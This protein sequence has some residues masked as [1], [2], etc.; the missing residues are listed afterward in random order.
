MSPDYI[1]AFVK[2]ETS[3]YDFGEERKAD[4]PRVNTRYGLRSFR[5]EAAR[6]WNSLP[7][8]VRPVESYL[9]FRRM[10]RSLVRPWMWMPSLFC[11]IYAGL[12][13]GVGGGGGNYLYMT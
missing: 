13:L 2:I 9:Q 8:E 11:L 5:P 7:N 6:I 12:R 3:T 4:V 1:N 10:V